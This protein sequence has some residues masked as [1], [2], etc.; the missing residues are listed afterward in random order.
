MNK[1]AMTTARALAIMAGAILFAAP[2][3][4]AS[5]F[6]DIP[7][8]VTIPAGLFVLGSDAAE[9]ESAYRLDEAAYGYR[10]TRDQGWYDAESPRRRVQLGA[11]RITRTPIT[12][13]QYQAFVADSGRRAPDIDA[14]TW[15]GYRLVHDFQATRRFAWVGG[16]AP[17]GRGRAGGGRGWLRRGRTA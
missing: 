8:L 13:A 7:G 15:A 6:V 11:F 3:P 5:E 1:P 17:T 16:A 10:V 2:A 12:N 4:Q 14:K 9:R